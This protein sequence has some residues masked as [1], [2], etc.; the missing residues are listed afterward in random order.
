MKLL[1]DNNLS[2]KLVSRLSDLFPC[3]THVM[4]EGM[5]EAEDFQI[6]EFAKKHEYV[7]VTKDSDYNEL[8]IFNGH[9]PKVILL[10]IGNSKVQ[11]I[12]E[13]IRKHVTRLK[14]FIEKDDL[15]LVELR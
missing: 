14:S 10:K 9:P 11:A 4:T 2:H 12:E 15:G 5:D 8:S 13:I 7:I 1:L 3:S 6:W